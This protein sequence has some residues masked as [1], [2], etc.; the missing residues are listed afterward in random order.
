M[1]LFTAAAIAALAATAASAQTVTQR[2]PM[3]DGGWD[4]LSFDPGSHRVFAGRSDG[5]ATLDV[6][7]GTVVGQLAPAQRTHAALVAG[8][9]GMG[10]VTSGTAGGVVLFDATTGAVKA[11]VPTGPKPD[12]AIFE[13][14]SRTVLVMDN[15]VGTVTMV[16]P[17][18]AKVTGTVAVGGALESP[19]LDGRGML[20]V[21]VE[22]KGEIAAVDLRT[23]AVRH[24]KVAGCEEPAGLA[25]TSHNVLIATC[26]NRVAKAVDAATGATIADLPIGSGPDS[27][28]Y[29]AKRERAYVATG[30]DGMMAVID[31][32]DRT[33]KVI[34]SVAT[35]TGAR[36][37]AVDPAT[38]IVYLIAAKYEPAVAGARPKA[39]PGT[40]E[41]L[42]VK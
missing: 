14:M 38:G 2:Y 5:V 36:T 6:A 22:D 10:A 37:G 15:K 31:T 41:I 39:V 30:R 25:L 42:A 20:Y 12:A 7:T 28:I 9:T 3:P 1:R 24:M 17:V 8:T 18:A 11:T 13:P 23:K 32:S 29:D 33:P 34:A 4:Y 21:A 40:V 19:A 27:V 26:A 35:Q 16:D